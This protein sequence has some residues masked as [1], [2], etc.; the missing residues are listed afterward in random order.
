MKVWGLEMKWPDI[1]VEFL[2]LCERN[3]EQDK[4]DF[5]GFSTS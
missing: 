5:Y 3:I 2:Q 1:L 4:N